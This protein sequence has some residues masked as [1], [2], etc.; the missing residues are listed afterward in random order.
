[1]AFSCAFEFSGDLAMVVTRAVVRSEATFLWRLT[2]EVPIP[3][4]NNNWMVVDSDCQIN[5]MICIKFIPQEW[6]VVAIG[7]SAMEFF[8]GDE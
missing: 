3:Q 2:W 4:C 7:I 5:D 8:V 1:M 6:K